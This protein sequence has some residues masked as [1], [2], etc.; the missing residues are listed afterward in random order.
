M[1]RIFLIILC[2]LIFFSL[3]VIASTEETTE[4]I[5]NNQK[6]ILGINDFLN[7]AKEYSK[8]GLG[9]N[10]EE[11]FE[12]AIKG[13]VKTKDIS[14]NVF[15]I[16]KKEFLEVISSI[17][18]ILIV[19]VIHSLFKSIS[20]NLGNSDTGKIAYYI[21][22]VLIATIIID[23][24]TSVLSITKESIQ[25]LTGFMYSLVPIMIT[26]MLTTGSFVSANS[27]QPILL[28]LTGFIGNFIE[29][30]L[31]PILLISVVLSLVSN[32]S[33]K[34]QINKLSKY[35]KSSIIWIL[36][37]ILTIFVS[38][39]S[40]EGTLGSSVDGV[41]AKATKAA[42]SNIIPVVGKILG[43][44]SDTVLRMCFINK[45]CCSE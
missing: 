15:K 5:I 37:I 6:D 36:G 3:P 38:L 26:L 24:F 2:I 30:F 18:G 40:L 45:K 39:L 17:I 19:L 44:A 43:D 21:Q 23:S 28:F 12:D 1:K 32:L 10:V 42:V 20:E 11:L 14:N 22:Y 27:I 31:L 7:E 9:E 16:I 25:N 8:N 13:N 41:T 34:I 29:L 4:E 35:L 33:E